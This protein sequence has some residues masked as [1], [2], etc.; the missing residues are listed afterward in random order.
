VEID[1]E[2]RKKKEGL[3]ASDHAPVTA[4]IDL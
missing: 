3:I 4:D 1:R 2:Y